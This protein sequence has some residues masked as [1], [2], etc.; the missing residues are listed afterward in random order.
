ML[1]KKKHFN[2]KNC[3]GISKVI[4]KNKVIFCAGIIKKTL[5]PQDKYRFC[6]IKNKIK[7]AN[8]IMIE[9]LMA[10]ITNLSSTYLRYLSKECKKRNK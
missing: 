3:N 10:M 5:L 9:E 8:D 6:I 7:S 2:C 1:D 4:F